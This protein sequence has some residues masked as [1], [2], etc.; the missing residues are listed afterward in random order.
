M[1]IPFVKAHGAKNDFL[2][3]SAA[4]VPESVPHADMARAICDRH[5]GIGADGWLQVGPGDQESDG[6]IRLYNSDGSLA[7]ISGNGTRCAATYL[8]Y[9]GMVTSDLVRI[10]TGA[11]IKH[12]RL[13][14]RSG[15]RFTFEMNMGAPEIQQKRVELPL[16]AGAR[17]VTLVWV[18][19]P[20]CAVPVEDL[21]FD[22]RA[23]G[24]E[25]E[26][27]PQFPNRTNVSFF[28]A[29]DQHTLEVRF[30]ERGAGE[31]MSSGT[32]STGA[33]TAA[34]ARGMIKTPVMVRTPAGPLELRCDLNITKDIYLIGPAEIIADGSFYYAKIEGNEQRTN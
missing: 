30:Y 1:Q 34:M 15:L 3:T 12:L 26:S 23:E 10:R 5:T 25:I 13:L 8:I 32:G 4:D 22:W 27:H 16:A 28:R 18:G 21:D 31:T 33:V 9:R 20:Q 11:G 19:N 6:T 14:D 7:E 29:V 2:L 17:D 24:A